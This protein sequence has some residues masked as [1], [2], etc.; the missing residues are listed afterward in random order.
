MFTNTAVFR[1]TCLPSH[2]PIMHYVEIPQAYHLLSSGLEGILRS[3]GSVSCP[4]SSRPI[5][6][7]YQF[8]QG[9][10]RIDGGPYLEKGVGPVLKDV[11]RKSK[12]VTL[13]KL[14]RIAIMP[15]ICSKEF[16]M[17]R[18][19]KHSLVACKSKILIDERIKD[20]CS[21]T[22]SVC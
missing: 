10:F 21:K 14:A 8:S 9:V 17:P 6:L 15:K 19:I 5:Q 12:G 13:R 11:T 7:T 20:I 16:L 4:F 3:R 18:I 22:G 1:T 2:F